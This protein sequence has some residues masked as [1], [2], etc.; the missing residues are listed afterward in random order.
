M[1]TA[2]VPWSPTP[3]ALT[4]LIPDACEAVSTLDELSAYTLLEERI[5]QGDLDALQARWE[6]GRKLLEERS[7]RQRLPTCRAE[8][9]ANALALS[10]WSGRGATSGPASA[11]RGVTTY[12]RTRI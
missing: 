9:I 12:R 10:S 5:R 3:T 2:L 8:S 11:S 4:E 6:F 1:S 7:G